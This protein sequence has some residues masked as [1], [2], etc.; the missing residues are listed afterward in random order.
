MLPWRSFLFKKKLGFN[1][2]GFGL[3][4]F[5]SA[6]LLWKWSHTT[7]QRFTTSVPEARLRHVQ[8]EIS[9]FS[10]HL[11]HSQHLEVNIPKMSSL[12]LHTCRAMVSLVGLTYRDISTQWRLIVDIIMSILIL[13]LIFTF[14]VIQLCP[15]VP[16]SLSQK[17]IFPLIQ[18]HNT[19]LI[20]SL[21]S[22]SPHLFIPLPAFTLLTL[23]IQK[24]SE[25]V[26]FHVW[27]F[28][29]VTLM[30]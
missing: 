18:D 23:H 19:S 11:D 15:W 3:V 26:F 20:F 4:T 12:A 1:F 22:L 6:A 27:C 21:L 24:Q 7:T 5:S 8:F 14:M 17:Q 25:P 13:T 29:N 9:Y 30:S 16:A 28:R 10:R 2:L